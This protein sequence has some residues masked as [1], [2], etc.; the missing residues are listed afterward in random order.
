MA[1]GRRRISLPLIYWLSRKLEL[2]S[3][4]ILADWEAPESLLSL[5]LRVHA[6]PDLHS[7]QVSSPVRQ[8][9]YCGTVPQLL[10]SFFVIFSLEK[11]LLKRLF[12]SFLLRTKWL[13]LCGFL[14]RFSSLFHGLYRCFKVSTM[15]LVFVL[16]QDNTM[17][18][19]LSSNSLCSSGWLWI[20]FPQQV[21]VLISI[22]KKNKG[23]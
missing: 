20:P 13:K 23:L 10:A 11:E 18:P 15:L 17:W 8:A 2:T 9:L 12:L 14:S 3:Q 5:P 1:T 16:R 22:F 6:T 4:A 19:G 7:C 21:C